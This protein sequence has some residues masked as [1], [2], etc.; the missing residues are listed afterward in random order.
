[1]RNA[2]GEVVVQI[3]ADTMLAPQALQRLYD[4]CFAFGQRGCAVGQ[5]VGYDNNTGGDISA[6]PTLPYEE[7]LAMLTRPD[8]P[9]DL[10]DL[11]A[12]VEHLIPWTFAWTGLL[13]LPAAAVREHDLFFD[14]GF[15]GWGVDDLEWGYRICASGIPIIFREDIGGLHLPHTR[16]SGVTLAEAKANWGRFLRKHP[17]P[18]AELAAAFGDVEANRLF[19]EFTRELREVSGGTGLSLIRERDTLTVGSRTAGPESLPLA[20]LAIPYRDASIAEC[21]IL[22][23]IE[24]FSR[25][26]RDQIH[27]EARRVAVQVRVT[28]P[29]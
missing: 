3:D 9:R 28:D 24:G 6:V 8:G 29:G 23:T 19:R 11:R 7:Y 18:A 22:P 4:Y 5:V 10:L 2:T 26:F 20:G 1:M 15:R 27:A 21:R 16:N 14:E 25:L 17:G 13:A 12:G